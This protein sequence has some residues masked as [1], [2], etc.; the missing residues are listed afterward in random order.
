MKCIGSKDGVCLWL[1]NAFDEEGRVRTD[2][3]QLFQALE[4][5]NHQRCVSVAGICEL[6]PSL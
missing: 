6:R 5:W 3:D 4:W 1:V 2:I